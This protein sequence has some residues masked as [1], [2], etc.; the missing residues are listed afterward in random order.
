V[1]DL[2]RRGLNG[3]GHDAGTRGPLSQLSRA[4]DL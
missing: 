2:P 4:P 1:R 3:D